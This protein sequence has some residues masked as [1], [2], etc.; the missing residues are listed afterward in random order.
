VPCWFRT[1]FLSCP[2]K[3]AHAEEL[4]TPENQTLVAEAD[5]SA[6]PIA[7]AGEIPTAEEEAAPEPAPAA[8]NSGS[9]LSDHEVSEDRL[10]TVL[11]TIAR[12]MEAKE[13]VSVR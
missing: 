13:L 11:E 5:S 1:V 2:S 12:D 3:N 10:A 6:Q 8:T 7:E 4:P 9:G